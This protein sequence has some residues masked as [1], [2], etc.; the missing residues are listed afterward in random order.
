MSTKEAKRVYVLEQVAKGVVSISDAALLLGISDRQ[1]QRLK[2]RWR[3]NGAEGLAH[4]SRGKRP[5]NALEDSVRST[6]LDF[7]TGPAKNASCS[8]LADLLGEYHNV[9]VSSKTIGRILKASGVKNSHSH[10]APKRFRRRPRLAQEGLMVILDASPH[11]WLEGRGPRMSLH[12][13]IDDATGKVL[14]L[15]FRLNEDLEGYLHV[16]D[17]IVKNHGVPHAAYTDRHTIFVSPKNEKLTVE[18]ELSGIK[19]PLTQFGMAI[20][21]LDIRHIKARTPQAKGR[22]ERLWG[23]LQERLVIEMRLAGIT[24]LEEANTFLPH[25]IRR[26]N[27]RFAVAAANPEQAYRPKPSPTLR[28]RVFSHREPRR[29]DR[30]SAISLG[31]RSYLLRATGSMKPARFEPGTIVWIHT[32]LDGTR[33]V[34]LN[35]VLHHLEEFEK[36]P[37]HTEQEAKQKQ[38]ALP[39]KPAASHPWRRSAITPKPQQKATEPMMNVT[40]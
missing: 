29:V 1:V 11:D 39:F 36:A 38:E 18:E 22:V 25:F 9:K 28:K 7:A 32:Q 3:E 21:D 10:R 6:I 23:T 35:G 2:S 8:H 34:L 5:A 31:G 40:L 13:G 37:V 26:H 27:E 16:M 24:A 20:N 17:Q 33:C 19:A 4:R 14:G 12:G 30:G 15:F